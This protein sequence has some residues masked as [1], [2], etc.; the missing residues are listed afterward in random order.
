[1]RMFVRHVYNIQRRR[2]TTVNSPRYSRWL[3][4]PVVVCVLIGNH[5]AIVCFFF[6]VVVIPGP[7]DI[8]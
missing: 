8:R 7:Y 6:G 3:S 2:T 4:G 1:M 5:V